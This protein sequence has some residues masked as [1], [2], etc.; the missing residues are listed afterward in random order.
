VARA[1][2]VI[3]YFSTSS[4]GAGDGT[5]WADRAALF[6]AGNWS[7]VISGFDF[8]S[9][10]LL[11]LIGPGT[12]SC[13]QQLTT[14]VTGTPDPSLANML[15]LHGCDSSGVI[16]SP[17][18][19]GWTSDQ[20]V[21]WDSSLPV[22]ATTGNLATVSMANC[23]LRLLK[24]TASGRTSG[25]VITGANTVDWIS[26]SNSASNSL[27]AA[28]SGVFIQANCFLTCTGT[29]YASVLNVGNNCTA[30]N[31]RVVG[32][33]GSSGNRDGFNYTATTVRAVLSRLTI[34]N[35][36]G[37]GFAYAGVNTGVSVHLVNCIIANNQGDGV[38]FPN[39]ASQTAYSSVT[40]CVITGNG[41]YGINPGGSNTNFL[42]YQ[43]R[44]RDNASGN[45]GTFGNYPTDWDNY[46][47]DS[48]DATEYNDAAS[49]D[50]RTKS[51]LPWS[52]RNIGVSQMSSGG[53]GVSRARVVNS[54]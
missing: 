28:L 43:N 15:F 40:K 46:I 12:Y 33:T 51:G 16:L 30:D 48:D 3:R 8:T 23:S 44:L 50:F 52:G 7:S 42:T 5:T 9:N 6:S 4:A 22:I 20:S 35:N 31:I 19:P 26:V 49:G 25:A 37:R 14:T 21:A 39:T 27:A 38:Q 24:F 45:F 32:V 29:A 11:C 17:S 36:G 54:Q 13:S 47:T 41:G 10:S 2:N 1:A 34:I 53:S 18:D